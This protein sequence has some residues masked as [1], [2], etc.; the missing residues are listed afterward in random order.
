MKPTR[1]WLTVTAASLLLAVALAWLI[2]VP[3]EAEKALHR[4]SLKTTH[5]LGRG[6]SGNLEDVSL[7]AEVE[8]AKPEDTGIYRDLMEAGW[9]EVHLGR[10][11]GLDP[12]D[13]SHQSVHFGWSSKNKLKIT[14]YREASRSEKLLDA[15]SRTFSPSGSGSDHQP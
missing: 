2:R 11:C 1:L 8:V 10:D 12:P 15:L 13:G 7:E 9:V 5:S 6:K 3:T 4:Y 14:Y